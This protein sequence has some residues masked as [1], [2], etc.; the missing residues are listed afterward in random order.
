MKNIPSADGFRCLHC[1]ASISAEFPMSGVRNRN[2]CPYCLWSRHLDWQSPGD[3][4]SSCKSAMRP[5]GLTLK[6]VRKKYGGA[7]AG[8][9]MVIHQCVDCRKVSINRIASDDGADRLVDVFLASQEEADR[10]GIERGE[11]GIRMLNRT[12]WEIVSRRLFGELLP[13]EEPPPAGSRT[14]S[15]LN[16]SGWNPAE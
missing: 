8:E 5:I 10:I 2:H 15:G 13:W 7:Q 4:L 16:P 1:R 11:R 14:E 3:R 6:N 12:D 9:L